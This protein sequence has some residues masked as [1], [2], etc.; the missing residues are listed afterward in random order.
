M[1]CT[2]QKETKNMGAFKDGDNINKLWKVVR[3]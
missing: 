3:S 2:D 1:N